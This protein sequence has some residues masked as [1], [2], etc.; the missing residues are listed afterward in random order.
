MGEID[1]EIWQNM[2][3]DI[4]QKRIFHY[5]FFFSYI[6]KISLRF[7]HSIIEKRTFHRF[8]CSIDT[9]KVTIKEQQYLTSFFCGKNGFKYF[10]GLRCREKKKLSKLF[11]YVESFEE[12]KYRL[13]PTKDKELFKN[14]MR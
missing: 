4:L 10:I 11:R 12:T 5:I 14:I 6:I 7:G 8:K 13:F 3:K 1:T 9:N 2:L